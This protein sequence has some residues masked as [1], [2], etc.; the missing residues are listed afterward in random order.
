MKSRQDLLTRL[1]EFTNGFEMPPTRQQWHTFVT[2][3][4]ADGARDA[5]AELVKAA[6]DVQRN[7]ANKKEVN[8]TGLALQQGRRL[9][10]E[11]I[12]NK[13]N[14]LQSLGED[15]DDWVEPPARNLKAE[16]L[17][18]VLKELKSGLKTDERIG[19][20]SQTG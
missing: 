4:Y 2:A 19:W 14:A 15:I 20:T 11:E 13:V 16:A 10:A 12:V 9:A 3:V 6:G 17:Q 1:I 5:K 7:A 8:E 18:D